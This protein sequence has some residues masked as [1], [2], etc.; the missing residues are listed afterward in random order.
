MRC[1]VGGQMRGV[2]RPLVPAL[3][4]ALKTREA[5]GL[6]PTGPMGWPAALF[7]KHFPNACVCSEKDSFVERG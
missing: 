7:T 1:R 6:V 5:L 3:G 4:E 2:P